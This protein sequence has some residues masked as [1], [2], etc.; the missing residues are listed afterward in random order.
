M[1]TPNDNY[2]RSNITGRSSKRQ[3]EIQLI[4]QI[5]LLHLL[6]KRGF[7]STQRRINSA[8]FPSLPHINGPVTVFLATRQGSGAWLAKYKDTDGRPVCRT[9]LDLWQVIYGVD[10]VSAMTELRAIAG[11][12]AGSPS[13]TENGEER[14]TEE[15]AEDRQGETPAMD[16]PGE[17]YDPNDPEETRAAMEHNRR[18]SSGEAKDDKSYIR[19][20]NTPSRLV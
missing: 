5:P 20:P 14:K 13:R 16:D 12:T 11:I 6:E 3:S 17:F 2:D 18:L 9:I 15:A 1:T 19:R 4:K 7:R 10:Y 8:V